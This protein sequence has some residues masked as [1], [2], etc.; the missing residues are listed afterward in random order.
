MKERYE[1]SI[2]TKTNMAGF[3]EPTL[4]AALARYNRYKQHA[5][6]NNISIDIAIYTFNPVW[7]RALIKTETIN[8]SR[9]IVIN[10]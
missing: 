2:Y 1:V 5:Q 3:T 7:G 9:V 6:K 4:E 8:P 10:A